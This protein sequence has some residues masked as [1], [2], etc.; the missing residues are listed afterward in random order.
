MHSFAAEV[1]SATAALFPI[2]TGINSGYGNATAC[3]LAKYV[4]FAGPARIRIAETV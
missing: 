1:A 2:I 4:I 3:G